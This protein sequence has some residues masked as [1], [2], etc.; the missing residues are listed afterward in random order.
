M[1][2]KLIESASGP[3][4]QAELREVLDLATTDIRVNRLGFGKRTSLADA[5]E[6]AGMCKTVL[7]RGDINA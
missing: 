1:L 6:I 5:I 3:I 7:G 2:K 4:S